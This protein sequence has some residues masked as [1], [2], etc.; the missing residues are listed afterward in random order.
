MGGRHPNQQPVLLRQESVHRPAP[1]KYTKLSTAM[2]IT[3][4]L[5]LLLEHNLFV[6]NTRRRAPPIRGD[7]HFVSTCGKKLL[8]WELVYVCESLELVLW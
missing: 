5:L 1:E 4:F 7:R 6:R 3:T 2:N 8:H